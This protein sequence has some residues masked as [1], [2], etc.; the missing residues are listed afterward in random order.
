[1]ETFYECSDMNSFVVMPKYPKEIKLAYIKA[2]FLCGKKSKN[3]EKIL[4]SLE[5]INKVLSPFIKYY[6]KW[7]G[8]WKYIQ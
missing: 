6:N 8:L 1:M 4:D 5:L 7:S 2:L 3:F